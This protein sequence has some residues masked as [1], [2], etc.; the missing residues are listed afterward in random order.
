MMAREGARAQAYDAL[1]RGTGV[2]DPMAATDARMDEES[3]MLA[4]LA[5][6]RADVADARAVCSGIRAANPS[7]PLWGDVLELHYIERLGWTAIGRRLGYSDEGVRRAAY[8]ALDWV[9]AVGIAAAR[10][11]VGRAW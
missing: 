11:G 8:A 7:H 4:E 9:D 3:R 5:A 2:S 1:P 10:D 6:Y